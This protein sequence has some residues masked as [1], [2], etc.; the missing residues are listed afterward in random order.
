MKDQRHLYPN[1]R[2]LES[3]CFVTSAMKNIVTILL[4]LCLCVA[5]L[6]LSAQWAGEIT[7]LQITDLEP[8][9]VELT[10]TA[11]DAESMWDIY[12]S[13]SSTFIP[14]PNTTPTD[15]SNYPLYSL[16]SLSP[17][18]FYTIYVR[19][20]NGTTE[21]IGNWVGI[22]FSTPCNAITILPWSDNLDNYTGSISTILS[23]SN[24]PDCWDQITDCS[25]NIETGGYPI[26]YH[27]A[28]FAASGNNAL[29]Y[30]L[31]YENPCSIQ[32]AVLPPIDASV[33]PMNTLQ[34]TFDARVANA[35]NTFRLI[36]GICT[37]PASQNN[38]VPIDTIDI[39]TST[40]SSYEILL[41]EYTGQ[42]N[43]IA[44]I[45]Q[46]PVSGYNHGYVDNIVVK[47]IT[48]CPKPNHLSSYNPTPS[49]ITLSWNET[50]IASNWNIEY[51]P[52]GFTQGNGILIPNISTN[53]YTIDNLTTGTMYDFYV[54]A[55]C[56]GDQ[57]SAWS[58]I[59]RSH[60]ACGAINTI[61]YTENFDY[62]GTGSTAYPCCWSKI[63][64]Y[65]S[66]NAYTDTVPYIYDSPYEGDGS[67]RFYANAPAT[68][69][70]AITPEIDASIVINTL[71]ANFMYKAS[72]TTDQLIVGL[73]SDPTD[74]STF[75]PVDT[76][77]P[78]TVPTSWQEKTVL[79]N[80]YTGNARY[81]A[82]K[83]QYTGTTSYGFID[84]LRLEFL[85]NCSRP[86]SVQVS[87]ITSNSI[88]IDWT[89]E[90]NENE[91]EVVAVPAG[92]D[93]TY[94]IPV[95]TNTHPFTLY[96]L[97]DATSY[98][99][100]VRALCDSAQH[101]YWSNPAHGTTMSFCTAPL[102]VTI[103]QIVGTSALLSWDHALSGAD[104]YTVLYSEAGQNIWMTHTVNASQYM[105]P[106]LL[107]TTNYEVMVYSNCGLRSSDTV[108][109]TFFTNCLLNNDWSIGNG[110]ATSGQLP[111]H[112]F[113]EYSYTQQ[114]FL[115][116]EMN[117][118]T[119]I[120]N[121][122]FQYD[123]H[124]AT[125]AKTNVN[126]YLGHTLQNSFS[127][128]SQ[129]IPL[130]DLQLV[131]SGSLNCTQGWNT[132]TFTTPFQ[133]NGTE[134]L[135][136][137]VDDNSG[138]YNNRGYECV[139][140][141]HSTGN[142]R[143]SLM[144]HSSLANPDPSNPNSTNINSN[145]NSC[146]R[147]N[148]IFGIACNDSISCIAPNVYIVSGNESSVTLDWAPG[149][150][151]NTWE[152]VYSD[153]DSN[154]TSVGNITSHPYTLTSL[155]NDTPYHIRIRS[156]CGSE[157]SEWNNILYTTSCSVIG[158]PY[159]EDFENAP[160]SGSGNMIPC[161]YA[162]T[163]YTSSVYP[164]TSSSR[165]H[166]GN[167]SV[168]FSGSSS[169][170]SY[171]VSPLL[172]DNV[173]MDYLQIRFW[174]YKSYSTFYIQVG[175][176]S[177]PD[178]PSTFVQVG[179]N[180]SP[181]TLATWQLMEV[182]T[183]NYTGNG[184]YIAFRIPVDISNYL[185]IDDVEI[186]YIPD[187][188]HVSNIQA[189]DSTIT[190]HSATLVWTPGSEGS[191]W[192]V[193]YGPAGTITDPDNETAIT[194][195]SP[196]ISLTD[197]SGNTLYDVYVREFCSETGHGIWISYSFLSACGEI[198]DL[199]FT[200]NF[201]SYATGSSSPINCWTRHNTFSATTNYPYVSNNYSYSGT[202]ALYFYGSGDSY[203]LIAT[204]PF[205]QNIAVNTLQVSFMMRTNN[206]NDSKLFIGVMTDP[207]DSSTYV[208][209]GTANATADDT[210]QAFNIPL[211][212]Y[213]G[214]GAYIVF[215]SITN[216]SNIFIDD[217]FIDLT[218]DCARPTN[219]TAM[220]N[221][222]DTIVLS[223]DDANGN[224]WD[225]IYGPTGFDPNTSADA[226][227]VYG[228]T[229]T[230]CVIAGLQGGINYD[231]YV[232]SDCGYGNVSPWCLSPA[233]ASPFT[234]RMGIN[235]SASLTGCG[236]T[237]T[238][239]GGPAGNYSNHCDYTLTVYPPDDTL[240]ISVSGTFTGEGSY[241]YLNIYE[242]A[243]TSGTL[244]QQVVSGTSG[245]T[246][247]FGPFTP[248]YGPLTL[249]FHSDVSVAYSGFVAHVNCVPA[250]FCPRPRNLTTDFIN[251]NEA[252]VSWKGTTHANTYYLALSTT[253]NFNPSTCTNIFTAY[254][255]TYQFT[256]L[257][258]NTTY[259][260]AVRA[261]CGSEEGD[262][263][264]IGSFTTSTAFATLPYSHGFEDVA[265]NSLWFL[266][267]GTQVN[268]WYIGQ[269]SGETSSVL[270]VSQNGTTTDY[271]LTSRSNV[272]AY[273]D[274]YFGDAANFTLSFD[275]KA[276]GET[277]Y[278]YLNV[279]I[280]SPV[281]P[282]A[283]STNAPSGA[284]QLGGDLNA[285]SS[286]QHFT[287]NLD[288]SYANSTKRLYFFW[289]NDHTSGAAPAAMIDNVEIRAFNCQH[290]NNLS[291]VALDSTSAIVSFTPASTNDVEWEYVYGE[292]NFNPD[293]AMNIQPTL[294][295]TIY[296][297]GLT[298]NTAYTIY[299]R[300]SCD[301]ND[302][303]A[304]S[305][306]LNFRTECGTLSLP[307]FENFDNI[308]S[309]SNA[310]PFCW[311][312][313]DNYSASTQYPYVNSS[314]HHSGNGSLYFNCSSTTYNLAVLP[315]IDPNI[316]PI[317]NLTLSFYMKTNS[318]ISN[319][320]LIIGAISDPNDINSFIP[321]DTITDPLLTFEYY[322][323][324]LSSY[325]GDAAYVAMK[326]LSSRDFFYLYVDDITLDI[327]A[328]CPIPLHLSSTATTSSSVTLSWTPGGNESNWNIEYGRAGFTPGTG[329]I[330]TA[331]TNPFTVTGLSW[332]TDYDFYVQA[333]C[334]GGN[335]SLW[336][337][338][339]ST[340]TGCG[341]ITTLP[342]IENFD[343]ATLYTLPNCWS[344]P[345]TYSNA[346]S[347]QNTLPHSEPNCV[348]FRSLPISSSI[349]MTPQI[350]EDIHN[351]RL[352][353]WIKFS[354]NCTGSFEVGLMDYEDVNLHTSVRIIPSSNNDIWTE[355]TIPFDSTNF[356]GTN[357][358]IGFRFNANS[359]S[360]SCWLDDVIIRYMNDTLPLPDCDVPTG[361]NATNVT[362]NAVDVSWT[363][364]GNET[365]WNL[366]YKAA[367]DSE[368][369]GII[370]VTTTTYHLSELTPE[371]SYQ[372][373]VQAVCSD[374]ETSDWSD[375]VSFTTL[376]EPVEPCYA[377]TNLQVS[378]I[379]ENSATITW[380]AGG[381]ETAW[382]L[383]YKAATDNE[384]GA[385]IP[386]TTNTY[387]LSGL[388]PETTYQVRLQ[389]VCGNSE[390]SDW[391]T[392]SFTTPAE[393]VEP[394]NAP[395]N[396]QVSNI[397]ENSATVAWTA[398]G[399]ETEWIVGY[400]LQSDNQWQEDTVQTPTF[401][402]ENL[403]QNSTYDVR[404]KAICAT[405]NQSDFVTS[406]FT[407]LVD[408][409]NDVK[410]AQNIILMPNPADNHIEL[411]VNCNIEVKEAVV[412]NAFVQM[413]Q[414]VQLTENHA[415]IDLSNM[416]AG[417]Y[418][419]R[420]NG[421][422]VTAMKK[423]IKR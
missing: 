277:N 274:F 41:N 228:F 13:T 9:S 260:Y 280:G 297:T 122:S 202:K 298:P 139:F 214:S 96:D 161:W 12:V 200:E 182:N 4:S 88:E 316:N 384:W 137:A 197:L 326:Y 266:V 153:N 342:F 351:L 291:L 206:A 275:W 45:A 376:E 10:W 380:T 70:I 163:S 270:F 381:S 113:S 190:A 134:N 11:A 238:D 50:G 408:A 337:P 196:S 314:Y 343:N 117:G 374:S 211:S 138:A 116:E 234:F 2:T 115:A 79:F 149:N 411:S 252:T 7:N 377:P 24:L 221:L 124:T 410:L 317:G 355:Y 251:A 367:G 404:V 121:I 231:F 216:Y 226:E 312:R 370:P 185:Y 56:G 423:F 299:V 166:S 217:I 330:V 75:I 402:M 69:N 318:G 83:N 15:H 232:R 359:V 110:T 265:E 413:I 390:T 401:V 354:G 97:E 179:Q 378:N 293:I 14:S 90:G 16:N 158:V 279:F 320:I 403:T 290:P 373:R 170:Y 419:V 203:N 127:N 62:Y 364:S 379:T 319:A 237:V 87:N 338:V 281:N 418:F 129:Y 296:L 23:T 84:N 323:I 133:Y 64:T 394:C 143:R 93:V 219:L 199:P 305:E 175:I 33:Y 18:T 223:W 31:Y 241:D 268:K 371:T 294:D 329:T 278:D 39:N 66:G 349:A 152:I 189:V 73:I 263:S 400:K 107:T 257:N 108:Y 89:P 414:T 167:Y 82:F 362:A 259:Y 204:P 284:V 95:S 235:G 26:L 303:S 55:D 198:T 249:L 286:W 222:S 61:P 136:V 285:Q 65:I 248:E 345:V 309:G 176:M 123:H 30:N 276:M 360:E 324:P 311:S 159:S 80:G 339:F 212:S 5:A 347:V 72:S 243:S 310:Y 100:Y 150:A 178:D 34:L 295:S 412:Y 325:T 213:T 44:I 247:N 85:L 42:G 3:C 68:Y 135:V 184:H 193:V 131:Y 389:A 307:I 422:G 229:T 111:L 415:R 38:F 283:G 365:A 187:C 224:L 118:A 91:W 332:G 63:S 126:I 205:D 114:I 357:K 386:V 302:K 246:V 304:W 155:N 103:S 86:S 240:R 6:P 146:L 328:T 333:D 29:F 256:N 391:T 201:E 101:S 142:E 215:K 271:S 350:A 363:A 141:V 327:T 344:R 308:G 77:T 19:A 321:I 43:R 181:D 368:W 81:I 177:D 289:H 188:D 348:W 353:F 36:V 334:G 22:S 392:T 385:I 406:T 372:V 49:S 250:P 169:Q 98:D 233:T 157:H 239:D 301:V 225:V 369:G 140:N 164:Y 17:N 352:S 78:G 165:H 396:L 407:T 173:V 421:E 209:V 94:G 387:H 186:D 375:A 269:P 336:S 195:Q 341:A 288:H 60:T 366:Q 361:L 148:V 331:T 151:E 356:S 409:I 218:P 245:T 120:R 58:A 119:E 262:W 399:N 388:T 52:A 109:K 322:E 306:V 48:T 220:S 125:S 21:I 25:S 105:I 242:G 398:G 112:N 53:P 104:N 27:N 156:I 192:Q 132:F 420:V 194:V 154:W 47:P 346:P 59:H 313:S 292:G 267:N 147:N 8:T 37:N 180:L 32:G 28:S 395:T 253:A 255:T 171:L 57:Q 67:L 183:D 287:M 335:T 54:Q 264:D 35:T 230:S 46:R 71:Q 174:A 244:L 207:N 160:G 236:Y 99:I 92:E 130:S 51:G 162:K 172:N 273:R 128:A 74:A 417:M 210:W 282:T 258:S 340:M 145:Y 191:S 106:D 416:A 1:N 393:P 144:Y 405:D 20:S 315:A 272:W 208:Q 300:T 102:N 40:F 227:T 382:N 168:Y 76:I 261:N 358:Y 397:T 383:Q 254:D